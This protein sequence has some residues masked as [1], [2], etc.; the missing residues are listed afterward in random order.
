MNAR[1]IAQALSDLHSVTARIPALIIA[2]EF[3]AHLQSRL[4]RTRQVERLLGDSTLQHDARKNLVTFER[5]V[6]DLEGNLRILIQAVRPIGSS[7]RLIRTAEELEVGM[8]IILDQMRYTTA[9]I[10]IE[11]NG[12]KE[13]SRGPLPEDLRNGTVTSSM[14]AKSFQTLSGALETFLENL[15]DIPEFEDKRLKDSSVAFRDWLDYRA[16]ALNA[17]AGTS[18]ENSAA[19]WRYMSQVM[20]E[21]VVYVKETGIV[22]QEFSKHGVTAIRDAQDRWQNLL[23]NISAVAALISAVTATTLQYPI[24][25]EQRF[26]TIIRASWLLSLFLSIAAAINSQ[27]AIYRRIIMYGSPGEALPKWVAFSIDFAPI[28][29]LVAAVLTFIVGLATWA[30]SLSLGLVVISGAVA[31]AVMTLMLCMVFV[32]WKTGER[33][34]GSEKA[35]IHARSEDRPEGESHITIPAPKDIDDTKSDRMEHLSLEPL[36]HSPT[37]WQSRNLH[38]KRPTPIFLGTR[39]DQV[40]DSPFSPISSFVSPAFSLFHR[41]AWELARDKNLRAAIRAAPM[42]T[43]SDGRNGLNSIRPVHALLSRRPI[44]RDMHFS[45]DGNYLAVTRVDGAIAIWKVDDLDEDPIIVQAHTERFAWSPDG[46]NIVSILPKGFQ[47]WDRD[48][49]KFITP[50]ISYSIGSVAWLHHGAA[51]AAAVD[52][53]VHLYTRKGRLKQEFKD[54]SR[55]RLQINDIAVIPSTNQD[56]FPGRYGRLLLV[57]T[58]VT[59]VAEPSFMKPDF[60]RPRDAK[61]EGRLVVYDMDWNG[62]EHSVEVSILADT[63]GVAANRNGM[64]G[65]LS[66]GDGSFPELWQLRNS[67]GRVRLE[68]CRLYA[69]ATRGSPGRVAGKA[70]FGGESDEWVIACDGENEIYV[71]DRI[72]G[73]M[74]HTLRSAQIRQF[75]GSLN[76]YDIATFACRT[77]K[78]NTT[79]MMLASAS[80]SGGVI[81]WGSPQDREVQLPALHSFPS[82]EGS[83][84]GSEA[85]S[86]G[87]SLDEKRAV[88]N[89]GLRA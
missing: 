12:S 21:M 27:L 10:W 55:S 11:F 77:T 74:L 66:F 6:K 85:A 60:K 69:P 50:Q 63:R 48:N 47:L 28:G 19:D 39:S 36:R 2:G 22:W 31:P 15:E 16:N 80:S 9:K 59:E 46:A 3:L 87:T 72:T 17:Y 51:F 65:L 70:H 75:A 14:L 32:I 67:K 78:D 73:H 64:F 35:T 56:E 34:R 8:T 1:E 44:G 49:R 86:T 68:L 88:L 33:L 30:F 4:E 62:Q 84:G 23:Q 42:G 37:K 89:N 57:G 45:P 81:I 83:I 18:F 71:W 29:C 79:E 52:G 5:V 54:L 20:S 40:P 24:A 53:A 43:T 41:R 25:E 13:R 82:P 7:S 76:A 26:E 38:L 61:P 58:V